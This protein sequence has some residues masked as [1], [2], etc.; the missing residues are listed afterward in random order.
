MSDWSD[1]SPGHNPPDGSLCNISLIASCR[2]WTWLE[3]G[4]CGCSFSNLTLHWV[5]RLCC[6]WDVG[7]V[8]LGR[9]FNS[10]LWHYPV[11]SE[12]DGRLSRVTTT[13]INS[14]LHP[15][16]VSKSSTSFRWDKGRKVTS[17]AWQNCVI[18]YGMWFPLIV[19]WLQLRTAISDLLTVACR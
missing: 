2:D 1:K 7:L 15:C 6:G 3:I 11:I 16:W 5:A 8:T 4:R 19:W 13:Q 9:G 14:A 17:T 12:I 10:R 18:P